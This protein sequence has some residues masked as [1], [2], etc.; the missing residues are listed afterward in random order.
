MSKVLFIGLV[1]PEPTSSAAGWRILHLVKLLLHN[2]QVHF[3]SAATKSPYSYDLK[4]LGV[5]EHQIELNNSSFDHF[6]RE[7]NPFIVVFDRFM[8]EEQYGWRIT[9]NVPNALKILDTED[10]HFLRLARQEAFKKDKPIHIYNDTAKREIAAILRC[11]LSLIISEFEMELLKNKFNVEADRLFFLPFQENKLAIQDKRNNYNERA[12][13]VFIGNFIHEPNW[14]TVEVLKNKIWPILRRKIPH[15]ELHIY[16]AYASEKVNQLHNPKERFFIKGR[17]DNARDTLEEYKVLLAPIPFGA[18]AKGKFVDAM[19]SGTPS[20]TTTVGAE[21]MHIN[22]QW[23]GYIADNMDEFIERA[24]YLYTHQDVWYDFQRAG[25]E[26]FDSTVADNSYSEALLKWIDY[27]LVHLNELRENN[28][29]GQILQQQQ[30][31]A[32]KYMSLWIEQKNK[33]ANID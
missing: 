26:I 11:D 9:E 4:S 23:G 12:N 28:F 24:I 22:N 14:R 20:V 29:I 7:L 25:F 15:A 3:V 8:I 21:N 17:A 10:L 5:T 1:W 27:A 2:H 13:F 33:N 6:V 32:T 16:G 30:L 19:F 18:G 31:N